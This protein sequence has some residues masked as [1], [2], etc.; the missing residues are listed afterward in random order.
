MCDQK[1]I[2]GKEVVTINIINP[3]EDA[4]SFAQMLRANADTISAIITKKYR[5][6]GSMRSLVADKEMVEETNKPEWNLRLEINGEKACEYRAGNDI[7]IPEPHCL[8]YEVYKIIQR[9]VSLIVP[10]LNLFSS[11]DCITSRLDTIS[12]IVCTRRFKVMSWKTISRY[13]AIRGYVHDIGVILAEAMFVGHTPD[14]IIN[15]H[16][17][18]AVKGKDK[19]DVQSWH[20]YLES[21]GEKVCEY[22]SGHIIFIPESERL[23]Y[24]AHEILQRVSSAIQEHLYLSYDKYS[25]LDYLNEIDCIANAALVEESDETDQD[26]ILNTRKNYQ[27]ILEHTGNIKEMVKKIKS[28]EY[29]SSPTKAFYDKR[30]GMLTIE[31]SGFDADNFLESIRQQNQS[32]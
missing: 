22:K 16:G 23:K 2:P 8:K 31:C 19:S 10:H 17:A 11:G 13:E 20:L 30:F 15:M 3:L 12:H 9:L 29:K 32:L 4:K 28:V 6:R 24:K 1:E 5:E 26:I 14:D 21:S 7:V 27:E 25:L 18:T